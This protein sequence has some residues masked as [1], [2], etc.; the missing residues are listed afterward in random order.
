MHELGE[1]KQTDLRGMTC[2]AWAQSRSREG[3]LV[4]CVG[5]GDHEDDTCRKERR[6]WREVEQAMQL[7]SGLMQG[8]SLVGEGQGVGDGVGAGLSEHG[9]G[10]RGCMRVV[11]RGI[12]G[13][14]VVSVVQH[15]AWSS[16]A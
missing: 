13:R 14:D 7:G 15:M 12:R 9:R 8:S 11:C 5:D 1:Q 3:S 4:R 10:M 2:C 6:S 16:L